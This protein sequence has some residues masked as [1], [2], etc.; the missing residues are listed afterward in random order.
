VTC[1]RDGKISGYRPFEPVQLNPF[2]LSA[3]AGVD[4]VL[5][6]PSHIRDVAADGLADL[7][8]F[9]QMP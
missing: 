5:P 6:V 4:R 3:V 2:P 9:S 7:S 8:T 1:P